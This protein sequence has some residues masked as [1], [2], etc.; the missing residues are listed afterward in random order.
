MWLWNKVFILVSFTDGVMLEKQKEG[1][2]WCQYMYL[3]MILYHFLQKLKLIR[4]Y[5]VSQCCKK[6]C[7]I[8]IIVIFLFNAAN[9]IATLDTSP[10]RCA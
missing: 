4:M 6:T 2:N 1:G 10:M 7:Y 9:R 3:S 8:E 5:I